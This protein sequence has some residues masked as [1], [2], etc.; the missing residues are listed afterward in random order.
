MTTMIMPVGT[1]TNINGQLTKD[2]DVP[3]PELGRS[4]RYGDGVFETIL[5]R[6]GEPWFLDDHI[7]RLSDGLDILGFDFQME[8]FLPKIMRELYRTISANGVQDFGRARIQVYRKGGGAYLPKKNA[9]GFIIEAASFPSDPWINDKPL[10][11]GIY[12]HVPIAPSP[13]T[14]IKSANA[15]PYIL[16]A[17]YGESNGWDDALMR[18]TDGYI[19]EGT[20]ANMFVVH[21]ATVFTP[22]VFGGCLPGVMRKNVLRVLK[23]RNVNVEER[24]LTHLDLAAANEIFLTSSIR[25]VMPV[26]KVEGTNYAP[27]EDL[28]APF[29]KDWILD[30]K[31][32]RA[33]HPYEN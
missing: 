17:K 2:D 9:P 3:K 18:S 12:H 1:L 10:Q 14:R 7:E 27:G 28:M 21:A 19:I 6:G 11:V 20:K 5:I 15:L 31:P 25:G 16:G 8:V 32:P 26:G 29:I 33:F 30:F 23:K 4:F 13:L 24:H 22:P